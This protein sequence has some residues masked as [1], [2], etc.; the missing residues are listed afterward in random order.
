VGVPRFC[1]STLTFRLKNDPTGSAR[2]GEV[3]A[4]LLGETPDGA[5]VR[6]EA[7]TFE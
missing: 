7:V 3:I 2:P 1:R 4:A 5:V 6:K